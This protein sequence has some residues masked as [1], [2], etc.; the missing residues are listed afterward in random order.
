MKIKK[1][2]QAKASGWKDAKV[3]ELSVSELACVAGRRR[4]ILNDPC[5]LKCASR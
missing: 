5:C 1:Q 3:V 2:K 4:I